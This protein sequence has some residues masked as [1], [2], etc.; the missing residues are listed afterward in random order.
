M[1]LCEELII[2]HIDFLRF[3]LASFL[4]SELVFPSGI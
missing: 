2:E 3:L 1:D 4:V